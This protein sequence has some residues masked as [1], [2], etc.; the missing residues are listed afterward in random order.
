MT[1]LPDRP[2]YRECPICQAKPGESCT[3]PTSTSRK[4]VAWFH[5]ERERV[6]Q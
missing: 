3:Q 4:V 5:S 2:I 1:E 6:E